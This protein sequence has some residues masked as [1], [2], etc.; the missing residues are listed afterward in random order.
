MCS[1]RF[2][3]ITDQGMLFLTLEWYQHPCWPHKMLR[4]TAEYFSTLW[5]V[6]LPKDLVGLHCI[7]YIFITQVNLGAF[8]QWLVYKKKCLLPIKAQACSTLC[9]NCNNPSKLK[10]LCKEFTDCKC[11]LSSN[12]WF[13]NE[14]IKFVSSTLGFQ[15]WMNWILYGLLAH[16]V[17]F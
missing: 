13:W 5:N 15:M 3:Q 7:I 12:L 17:E 11:W 4:S 8:K 6:E 16:G 9:F 2:E 1:Q 14:V 10:C